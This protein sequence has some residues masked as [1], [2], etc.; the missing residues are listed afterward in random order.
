[1]YCSG[2]F[3]NNIIISNTRL[4]GQ[5]TSSGYT[6]IEFDISWENS[7]RI[8]TDASNW[9]AAWVFV[10]YRVGSGE[11]QHAWL[12]NTGHTAPT[13]SIIDVGLLDPT[14]VFNTITNPCLGVFIYRNSNGM[15]TFSLSNVKLQWNYSAN[16]LNDNDIIDFQV[17]AIE[18]VYVPQGNFELGSGGSG[19]SE[20][21]KYPSLTSPYLITDESEITVG[22]STD[23]LYYSTGTYGGDQSGPVPATFPKGFNA[24]YC[25]KYEISQQGYVD[26]LNN[27]NQTQANTRKF[28]TSGYRYY[29]NG[30]TI[31]NYVTTNPYVACNYLGWDDLTSYFDWSGLRPMT[32]LEFEKA[33]RGTSPAVPNEYAWGNTNLC[34]VPYFLN[35]SGTVNEIVTNFAPSP[36]GNSSYNTTDGSI[37]G[38]LRVGIFATNTSDRIESGA[39][40]YGIMDMSGNLWERAVTIG[41]SVGR[42]FDGTMGDGV[43]DTNGNANANTWPGT[44]ALGSGFLGGNWYH[45]NLTAG[46]NFIINVN[47]K[48]SFTMLSF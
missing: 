4:T 10:K 42:L 25:M 22:T 15:G 7:W 34:A 11:W 36:N 24:F 1:M 47:M 18:M 37:D 38:P 8:S 16:G 28:T 2:S 32:E 26:F 21:Y 30:S 39:T 17:F 6:M 35:N 43:L 44:D 9:D 46:E 14:T 41:H 13:G 40:Y 5:N 45:A 29:I 19:V 12:N 27:L 31:G 3:A 23:N 20:F 48:T 33:C